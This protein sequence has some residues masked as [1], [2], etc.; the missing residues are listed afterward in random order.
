MSLGETAFS[1]WL[2]DEYLVDPWNLWFCTASDVPGVVPNQNPIESHHRTIKETAVNHLRAATGH[3]LAGT[4]PRVL[5]E[6]AMDIGSEQIRHFASGPVGAEALQ[7]ALLLCAAENHYPTHARKSARFI[8]DIKEYYFNSRYYVVRD[9]NLHSLKVTANR[10]NTYKRSLRGVL[11]RNEKVE[12]IQLRYQSLH[13]VKV[14]KRVPFD[15]DWSKPSW[16]LEE[17]ETILKKFKCDCKAFYQTGWLC[18][19]VLA[20]LHLVDDLDLEVMLRGLPARKP[21]GR[22]RKK[23]R[24]LERDGARKSQYTVNALVKRLVEK[25]AS[26]INWSILRTRRSTDDEGEEIEQDYVGKVKPPFTRGGSGTGSLSM[27]ILKSCRQWTW[28]SW[29]R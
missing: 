12:N 25:P 26:V 21:P 1:Q 14:T 29:L 3:V 2:Q 9:D 27:K 17:I 28:R 4:L 16:S 19:H 8:R 6:C 5:V 24:C 11:R 18:A 10:T 15:H 13:V 23:T 22:P 7:A 20:C